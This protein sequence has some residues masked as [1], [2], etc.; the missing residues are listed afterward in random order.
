MAVNFSVL[1][2]R[3]MTIFIIYYLNIS[4]TCVA[5]QFS[6]VQ[7]SV[8]QFSVVKLSVVHLSAVQL[9]VVHFSVVQ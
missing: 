5:M 1:F 6:V 8:V 9:S 3:A 4:S 7:F 2:K